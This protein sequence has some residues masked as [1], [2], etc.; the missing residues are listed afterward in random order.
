MAS[1]GIGSLL[2]GVGCWEAVR[3]IRE[4]SGVQGCIGGLA[5]N[6]CTQGPE[7]V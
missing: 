6:L 1:G 7:G 2:W 4:V 5:G 3:G